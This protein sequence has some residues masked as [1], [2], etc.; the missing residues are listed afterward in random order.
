[1]RLFPDPLPTTSRSMR[2]PSGHD[3]DESEPLPGWLEPLSRSGMIEVVTP[4]T[5][6]GSAIG[7]LGSGKRW[8]EEIFDER[9][10]QITE[11]IAQ[12]AGL[13][14]LTALQIEQLRQ[15]PQEIATAQ[16]RERFKIAQELH[17]TVQQFLGRLPF[18]LEVSRSSARSNPEETEAILKR[19]IEDVDS[20]AKAVRQIRNNLAPLQLEKSLSQPLSQLIEHFSTRNNIHV[21]VSISPEVDTRLSTEARHALYRVV[22]QALDNIAAHAGASNVTIS[23]E[24]VQERLHFSITDDGT[25]FSKAQRA[26]AEESGSFGLK[27]MEAR[28]TS[29][30]GE[31]TIQAGAESGTRVNGWLPMLLSATPMPEA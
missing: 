23:I 21:D 26:A 28:I 5:I 7:L 1:M 22:Q 24:P 11:L 9:D 16:E 4:L 25:G 29:Q 31:F 19:C 15:V 13:F 27:S 18:F 17:D 30:G 10:L 14:L 6:S 12:Q 20:A 8:D 2:I 3:V